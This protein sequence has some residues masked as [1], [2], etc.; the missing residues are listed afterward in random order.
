MRSLLSTAMFGILLTAGNH[1]KAA[2]CLRFG[3]QVGFEQLAEIR[4]I[5]AG[6]SGLNPWLQADSDGYTALM[7][8]AHFGHEAVAKLLLQH[9]A[10][11]NVASH[12]GDTAL[13]VAA[14]FLAM[15]PWPSSCCSTVLMSMW[16]VTRVTPH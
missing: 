15:R 10:D 12:E 4:G 8:A 13:M 3:A 9:G 16:Q 7:V 11:F 14:H 1:A 6:H 2:K 5:L